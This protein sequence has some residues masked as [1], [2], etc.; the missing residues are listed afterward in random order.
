[1]TARIHSLL[2]KIAI[3]VTFLMLIV[4]P[5]VFYHHLTYTYNVPRGAD[6]FQ[7]VA[8]RWTMVGRSGSCDTNSVTLR[9]T[10]DHA[11]MILTRS[12]PVRGPDGSLDSVSRYPV[13]GHTLHSIQ[14]VRRGETSL[15]PD[16]TP[17]IWT[18]VLRSPDRYTW[19]RSDWLPIWF[20]PELRRCPGS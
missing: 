17:V 3:V 20:T 9:F 1:M 18:L 10:P 8:G 5:G 15:N 6:V 12:H 19:H 13:I 14:V 11:D 2:P 7:T 4:L 16:S